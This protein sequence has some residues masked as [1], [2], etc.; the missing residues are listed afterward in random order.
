VGGKEL[1]ANKTEH[2]RQKSVN[3]EPITADLPSP[4]ANS[5]LRTSFCGVTFPNPV[6]L[7]SG[8]LG[9]SEWVF[10]RLAG[11]GI[12]GVTTK[13][14]SLKPRTGWKNPVIV[15][16]GEGVINAVGLANPGVEVMIEEIV[17]AKRLL[18]PYGV[19]IIASIFANTLA[20]YAEM[21]KRVNEAQ[22]DLIE[23]NISCPNLDA[24][25]EMMFSSD[26]ELSAQATRVVK[27]NAACPIVV[28]LSPNVESITKIALAVANAGADG[29]CAINSLGPGIVL[30]IETAKPVLSNVTGGVTGAAIRPI[31]V[32]CVRDICAALK[33]AKF[34]IPVI[35]TGGVMNGRDAV[36]MILVGATLVGVGSAAY[37]GLNIFKEIADGIA[38][39]MHRHDY[40]NVEEFSGRAL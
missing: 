10:E 6:V 32:R 5:S 37:R 14:C 36:E 12:G 16:W 9:L 4:T 39:Y 30:D 3:S 38:E 20:E 26:P 40:Y 27:D 1:R 19:P 22:P 29:I 7:A 18:K 25:H 31:A 33:A 17:A 8:I 11:G 24:R 34:N 2:R 21:T 23:V 35:G 15:N 13:S 28:K